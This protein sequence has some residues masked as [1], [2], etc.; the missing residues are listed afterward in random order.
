[1]D[2]PHLVLLNHF[3]NYTM[4]ILLR[5]NNI[6]SDPRASKYVAVFK[7]K[8]IP[9]KLIGWDRTGSNSLPEN[10]FFFKLK[11]SFGQGGIKAVIHRIFWMTYV[12][13]K[14]IILGRKIKT[15]HA[16]DLDCAFPACVYKTFFN[17]KANIIFDVFDWYSATL[18]NQNTLV[19]TAFRYM[20][21]FSIKKSNEVIICEP[22]RIEQIPYALNNEALVF[23]NIPSFDEYSF[24]C[25]DS[26]YHFDNQNIT[27]SYVGGF[28]DQRMLLELL[29]L[30]YKNTFNL[31]IAGYGSYEITQACEK[32]NSLENVKFLG[33]VEYKDGLN[34]MFNS[35]VIYA[36]YSKENPNHIYA[37]PNKFY[38]AMLLGK[39]LLSNRG[40]LL[41]AK[42]EN[43]DIGYCVDENIVSI[44]SCIKQL[45]KS[46]LALKGVNAQVLWE[47]KFKT[48]SRDFLTNEYYQIIQ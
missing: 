24:L 41:Q 19:K 8:N 12:I 39:P 23:P 17:R 6:K 16:C 40:I 31:L 33:K 48:M 25:S 26:K 21:K 45:N 20:E 43:F 30:S 5:C 1:M 15:I 42:I 3:N 46:E 9:Y 11:S 28:Y 32:A 7:E 10:G 13:Y 22:E 18:Y 27:I 4:I 29:Q 47:S 35:D 37:A 36:M 38:E 14:L 2:W 44:E 34:L